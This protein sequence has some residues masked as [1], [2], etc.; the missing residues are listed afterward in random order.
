MKETSL[1]V[2]FLSVMTTMMQQ[3]L[4]LCAGVIEY[5]LSPSQ[6]NHKW[7]FLLKYI[8]LEVKKIPIRKHSAFFDYCLLR[9]NIRDD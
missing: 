4:E 6:R 8:L 5:R 2:D 7:T 1:S 9:N 3:M